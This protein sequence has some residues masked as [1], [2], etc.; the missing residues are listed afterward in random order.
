MKGVLAGIA[1]MVTGAVMA[2]TVA[3]GLM[4]TGTSIALAAGAAPHIPSSEAPG[5]ER[6]RFI[7][8]PG[9]KLLKPNQPSTV[10][11]YGPRS[12]ELRCRPRGDRHKAHGRRRC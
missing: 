8:P 12:F 9:A 10:L 6:E 3:T 7:D 4:M 1:F 11:P 2:G 5:R